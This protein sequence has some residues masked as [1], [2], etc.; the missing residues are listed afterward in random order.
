MKKHRTPDVKPE[1]VIGLIAKIGTDLEVI[2][3][4]I[5]DALNEYEYELAKI[6]ITDSLKSPILTASLT[7]QIESSPLEQR[8]STSMDACN[9]LR[10]KFGNE[11]MAS[12]AVTQIS[13]TRT[14]LA[15]ATEIDRE[16]SLAF[17]VRQLKRKEE[18]DLMRRIYGDRFVL[19]SCYAPREKRCSA[20]ASELAKSNF[21]QNADDY[22]ATAEGLISRDENETGESH[23]QAVR[24]AFPL[25]DVIIDASENSK[26][27][28]SVSDFFEIFFGNPKFSPTDDEYGSF[29]ASSASLRSNDL[30]RQVGA[31]I[32]SKNGEVLSLGCNEVPKYSGGTYTRDHANSTGIDGRDAEV[33]FDEN[34]KMKIEIAK[35]A[36]VKIS[37][38][39]G[40]DLQ[41]EKIDALMKEHMYSSE[42]SLKELLIMDITEFGRAVHAE[43]NAIT[44]AA[45]TGV[46]LRGSVLY[47]TTYPCHNCA[48]HIVASGIERVVYIQPYPKSKAVRLYP[49]SIVSDSANPVEGKVKF[50]TH[51][52]VAPNIYRRLFG[53]VKKKDKFG[54]I[55]N[56]SKRGAMP[57][58]SP[59]DI[60]YLDNEKVEIQNVALLIK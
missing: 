45:R 23:G 54:N 53:K 58:V 47:C 42:A 31:A 60:G 21:S 1:L 29:L 22:R 40:Q 41:T 43:M 50:E 8:I 15:K 24:H 11:F 55:I 4:A 32:F 52:G 56:W 20:L 26:I 17:V 18:V 10:M 7:R 27:R 5:S 2:T 19:M 57:N 9:D 35:D 12:L 44:D 25:A 30:S 33:G 37:K 59:N 3:T 48:K 34:E 28:K 51:C 6:K 49:D 39:L 46:A 38:I 16:K 36:L 13:A 14:E